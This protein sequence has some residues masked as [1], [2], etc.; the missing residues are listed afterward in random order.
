MNQISKL[1]ESIKQL[2][3]WGKA[4]GF[5]ATTILAL[6][7]VYRVYQENFPA[8]ILVVVPFMILVIMVAGVY[9]I[10]ARGTPSFIGGRSLPLFSIVTRIIAGI[11]VF[12]IGTS[13]GRYYLSDRG[14]VD[15]KQALHGT[16]TPTPTNTPLPTSTPTETLIPTSTFTATLSPTPTPKEHGVYYM[17]VLDASL[18][19]LESFEAESKWDAAL[20][21]VT[22]I[23]ETREKE[24]NYGLVV[25]GGSGS[26]EGGN[27]CGQPSTVAIPFSSRDIVVDHIN[28][29]QP[30][31]GGSIFTAFNLAKDQFRTL[32]ENTVRTLVF[33][34]GSSDAC[35]SREEWRDLERAF[36]FPGGIGIEM[37][38]EIIVLEQN[39]VISR[40]IKEQFDSLSTNLNV[41]APQTGFQLMQTNNTVI[42]NISNYV[43][44][45]ISSFPN[46]TPAPTLTPTL[47][48]VPTPTVFISTAQVRVQVFMDR[49]GNSFPDADEWIDSMSVLLS[50]STNQQITQRTDNGVTIFDMT[51]FTPG[52]N[53]TVSLPGLLRSES[54]VL[55]EQGE[56]SVTFMFEQPALPTVLP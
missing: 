48:P 44:Y 16:F 42:N 32:P 25:I 47:T 18:S 4:L 8:F 49:N 36:N 34:T 27:P 33:I 14:K 30:S 9:L 24:A 50:T 19:M 23:L 31:G 35:E 6:V 7:G 55:P 37:Y 38:S 54:F 40:T 46:D 28:Q 1:T 39:A 2:P 11:I 26:Q 29:L 51:G 12:A 41:Q 52:I 43:N 56:V 10:F 45:T 5:L 21:A 22:A 17:I 13:S 20:R 3:E 53:I 15:V